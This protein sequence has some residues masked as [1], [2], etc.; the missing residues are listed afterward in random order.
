MT[1]KL[2]SKFNVFIVEIARGDIQERKVLGREYRLPLQH[3]KLH[4]QNTKIAAEYV[5]HSSKG[6]YSYEMD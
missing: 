1:L 3:I 4:K 5:K 2:S 6:K